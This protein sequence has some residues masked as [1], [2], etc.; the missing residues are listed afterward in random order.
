MPDV[1]VDVAL[2]TTATQLQAMINAASPGTTFRLQAGTYT[3]DKTVVINKDHVSLVGAGADQ[4]T[5]VAA[6]ALGTTAPI[7][8][9]HAL[10][11]PVIE[12]T[13]NVTA[14][15]HT[16]DTSI[17][18]EA[19]HSIA[20]GDVI[21]IA[22]ENT[23]EYL[24]SIG[25]NAWRK[26]NPLR[27]IMVTV[28]E[29]DG[30]TISFD[31]PL[32]FDYDPAISRV[33][34]RHVL[35]GNSLSGFTIEGAYGTPDPSNFNNVVGAGKGA[36]SIM[37]GGTTGMTITD[38]A[39]K[40]AVSSG[41]LISDSVGVTVTGFSMDGAFNKGADGNGYALWLR[42]VYDSSFT[43]LDITNTRHAVVFAS[44]TTESG[45]YV[46]VTYTN[47]DINF[48]GGRDQNNVVVVDVSERNTAEQSYMSTASFF[49]P[50]TFYGAP[51]DPSK[52]TI[53]FKYVV[54]SNKDDTI[55]SH[56][57]GSQVY[58]VAGNDTVH[59]G[60]GTDYVDG[61]TGNDLIYAS[62]GNDEV[63][64]GAGTD[65]LV[66]VNALSAYTLGADGAALIVTGPDGA[67]RVTAVETLTFGNSSYTFAALM[68]L[69]G[70]GGDGGDDGGG[71]PPTGPVSWAEMDTTGLPVVDGGSGWERHT[72]AVSFVMGAGLEGSAFS[73]S[74]HLT[75]VGNAL[76][77][78]MLGNSGANRMEGRA[79][80]DKIYGG[81]GDDTLIGG[82][83]NDL[84][85]GSGGADAL[86]GGAG[87]DSLYG[88]DDN[89]QMLA[90][91]GIDTLD[92]D[93]GSDSVIFAGDLASY[94]LATTS[95]GFVVTLGSDRSTV[96]D[97]ETFLFNGTSY[98]AAGLMQAW[99]D[100]TGG[101]D[102]GGGDDGG[103]GGG[104]GADWDEIDATGMLF[105]GGADG[106]QRYTS[107][108][109]FA[110][111]DGLEA[112]RLDGTGDLTVIGNSLGNAI[113]G[114]DGDN[115][116]EGRGGADTIKGYDGHDTL[117]GGAGNDS[118]NAGDD[119]DL[120]AGGTG[121]DRMKGGK[122]LDSFVFLTGDGQDVITDFDE[123]EDSLLLG[124]SGFGTLAALTGH[125][126]QQ[127]SDVLFDFGGGHSLLVEDVKVA[128]ILDHIQFV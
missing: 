28:T 8:V 43:D 7:Q 121:N 115:R 58:T 29:V 79:G 107:L 112:A 110:M 12:D 45:N 122:G 109:S 100:A 23:P 74:G 22:A 101:G 86:S 1:I 87:N 15:A 77:N 93:A 71:D 84:L 9:G 99:L 52:N 57:D 65:R 55:Y 119:N 51:T 95:G 98:S 41:L 30:N 128:V 25:D 72:S 34:K 50:G 91:S 27:T 116:I 120:I 17:Q 82:E 31:S 62:A 96:L 111:G 18:V 26:D 54:A 56:A 49:N 97:T 5:I 2:G 21:Y 35:E 4:T 24:D 47:R 118:L 53:T 88:G 10:Y 114:N 3:F 83:G 11:K 60:A 126:T 67:T 73:G 64:G 46:Q 68:A 108:V 81:S 39:I 113:K 6:K 59:S 48:H 38:V 78:N 69:A 70:G 124:V 36:V 16:G 123:D 117:L 103:G 90:G 40:N 125:V 127:G 85:Q 19:G 94:G 80:N 92:G 63:T 66:F 33:E 37:V 14:A 89:D 44:Y 42:E 102:D 32:T 61:G 76:D 20:V 106:Y 104:T 75:V 105:I 13:F